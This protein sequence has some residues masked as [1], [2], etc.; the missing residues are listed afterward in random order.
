MTNSKITLPLSVLVFAACGSSSADDDG[1]IDANG[2]VGELLGSF[3]VQ[4]VA[5]RLETDGTTTPGF[6]S[7]LGKVYDGVQPETVIWETEASE[8][9]CTLA[10]PRVPFCSVGCGSTA[11]CVADETCQ[12]YPTSQSVGAATLAGVHTAADDTTIELSAVANT[13]QPP[14]GVTLAYPGFAEGDAV[15]V[16]ASGSA[17]TSAF[18]VGARG[19]SSLELVGSAAIA[20]VAGQPL[21]L[22]WTA[23]GA[24]DSTVHVKLDISHHGGSKGKV[25][26]DV[27]DT[28]SLALP[29]AMVDRLL[30]LGAAGFPT[31]IVTRSTVGHA[32]AASGHVDLV[33]SSQVEVPIGVPGIE[34][35]TDDTDC[36]APETCQSDL[37]CK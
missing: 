30:E 9:G 7:V 29:A 25:E 2:N 37:T 14:A 18:T 4:L 1:A 28:G 12:P 32:A 22:A 10:T 8:A 35:C 5:P 21:A 6:T 23:P 31:V 27:G 33:V 24:G 3:T 15:T 11:A 19:V 34:S 16:A 17:F 13:Y 20:L 26:C 36:T